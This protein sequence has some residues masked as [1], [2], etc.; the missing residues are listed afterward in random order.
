MNPS[1]ITYVHPRIWLFLPLFI[2]FGGITAILITR[3]VAY[4]YHPEVFAHSLPTIS[5][6]AALEYA[7][8]IFSSTIPIIA[9]CVIIAWFLG[10]LATKERI[11]T[12]TNGTNTSKLLHLNR[13]ALS[14]GVTS[15]VFL[16]ALAVVSLED[17]ND[18]HIYYSYGF[19]ISQVLSFGFDTYVLLKIRK[20]VGPDKQKHRLG[21]DLRPWLCVAYVAN[22][23]I[24]YFLYTFKEDP[25]LVDFALTRPIYVG[26]EYSFVFIG[27]TYAT[28]YRTEFR[29]YINKVFGTNY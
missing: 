6:T 10:F 14:M 13:I 23:L 16:A 25:L 17:N 19:F 1:I 12:L 24:F 28:A 3:Y 5:K 22:A 29:H 9:T 20:L 11:L 2:T 18:M 15:G 7:T 26:S 4:T 21:F 27:I 8:E